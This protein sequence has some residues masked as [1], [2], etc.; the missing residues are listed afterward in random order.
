MLALHDIKER[1]YL[2]IIR[3]PKKNT[4]KGYHNS[5]TYETIETNPIESKQ[6]KLKE[7]KKISISQF[8]HVRSQK[9]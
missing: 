7:K 6:W 3:Y 4:Q 2:D 5:K 9:K 8:V 1:K